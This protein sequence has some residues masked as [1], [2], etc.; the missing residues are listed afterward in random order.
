MQVLGTLFRSTMASPTYS[1]RSGSLSDTSKA[2]GSLV[3]LPTFQVRHAIS[4]PHERHDF[5]SSPSVDIP[6]HSFG[7]VGWRRIGNCVGNVSS[8]HTNIFLPDTHPSSSPLPSPASSS[9][10][11]SLRFL[12]IQQSWRCR[13]TTYRKLSSRAFV[14]WPTRSIVSWRLGGWSCGTTSAPCTTAS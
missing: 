8:I 10:S 13:E 9:S 12:P 4:C 6:Q 11:S 14:W 2:L 1:C 7:S 3:R 5:L